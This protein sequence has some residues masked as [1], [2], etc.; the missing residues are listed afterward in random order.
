LSPRFAEKRYYEMDKDTEP[1]GDLC[2][3]IVNDSMKGLGSEFFANGNTKI[4]M[5]P[6][7]KDI[8]DK[9]KT[10]ASLSRNN[11]AEFL[12]KAFCTYYGAKSADK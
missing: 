8:L 12:K 9:C 5:M 2:K 1:F 7:T 3:Q 11:A 4:L 10:R 6:E